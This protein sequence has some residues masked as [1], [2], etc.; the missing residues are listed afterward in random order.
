M[1]FKCRATRHSCKCTTAGYR[2]SRVHTSH[3]V[4]GAREAVAKVQSANAFQL[5]MQQCMHVLIGKHPG[6]GLAYQTHF[7][8]V[9]ST[10][11]SK[12]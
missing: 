9:E 6:R 2:I 7:L 4:Y 5:R 11:L 3:T 8:N 1:L 10:V 12:N